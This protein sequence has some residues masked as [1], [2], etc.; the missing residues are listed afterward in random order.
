M[1]TRKVGALALVP[2]LS[3]LVGCGSG[4]KTASASITGKVLLNGAVL[5]GGN[6]TLHGSDGG[7]Y[8]DTITADGEFRIVDLPPGE[9]TVTIENDGLDPNRKQQTYKGGDASKGPGAMMKGGAGN[10]MAGKYGGAMGGS[11]GAPPNA[12][13]GKGAETYTPEGMTN[14]KEGSYVAIPAKFK[15]KDTTGVKVTLEDGENKKDIAFDGK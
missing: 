13:K 10:P 8:S 5:P 1:F 2:L 9:Y 3:V 11:G 7:G 15:K 12:Y 14:V 6:V 4:K